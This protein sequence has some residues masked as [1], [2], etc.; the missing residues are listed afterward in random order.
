MAGIPSGEPPNLDSRLRGNDG[1][2]K[3]SLREN[4]GCPK[5]SLRENDG[6]AKVRL[7]GNPQ[8]WGSVPLSNSERF[9]MPGQL[10]DYAGGFGS[11]RSISRFPPFSSN[12]SETMKCSAISDPNASGV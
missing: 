1:C 12:L 9:L 8:G 4:D 10:E 2:A 5:V 3:V 6:C 7:R 11:S